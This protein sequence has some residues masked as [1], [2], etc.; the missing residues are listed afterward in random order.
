MSLL[1]AATDPAAVG[2]EYYG[3]GGLG[4]FKGAPKVVESSP[5]ARVEAD[6]RR[7][8]ALSEEATGVRFSLPSRQG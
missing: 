3:P 1:R 6:Q 2:G 4:E 8:W 5:R 7:L